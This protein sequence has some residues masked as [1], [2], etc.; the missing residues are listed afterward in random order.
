MIASSSQDLCAGLDGS[1]CVE[2]APSEGGLVEV[3]LPNKNLAIG[4]L[5][6]RGDGPINDPMD[7]VAKHARLKLAL[8]DLTV[9]D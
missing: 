7:G 2:M 8:L 9:D 1:L 4:G 5:Q 6:P 3:E